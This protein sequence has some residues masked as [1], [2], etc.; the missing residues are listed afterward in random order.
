MGVLLL[1]PTAMHVGLLIIKKNF[2]Y[3]LRF[4]KIAP[5]PKLASPEEMEKYV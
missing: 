1:S 2:A 4:L 3:S 5:Y